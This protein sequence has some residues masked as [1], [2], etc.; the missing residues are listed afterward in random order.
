MGV[1]QAVGIDTGTAVLFTLSMGF[2]WQE[3]LSG[4]PFPF[5]VNHVLSAH[6][7]RGAHRL[8]GGVGGRLGHG[9]G[10]AGAVKQAGAAEDVLPREHARGR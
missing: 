3:Y 10:D 5:P 6:L 4:L 2:S 9:A 1:A 8:E 7:L